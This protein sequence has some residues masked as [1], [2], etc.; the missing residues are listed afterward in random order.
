MP[1]P[2]GDVAPRGGVQLPFHRAT[3]IHRWRRTGRVA[4]L[5]GS[6][7]MPQAVRRYAQVFLGDVESLHH[8]AQVSDR[9]DQSLLRIA[10][11]FG[12]TV[13]HAARG[14]D[15]AHP[16]VGVDRHIALA[17]A[18]CAAMRE[19]V[20]RRSALRLPGLTPRCTPAWWNTWSAPAAC[21]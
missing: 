5:V 19:E 14:L 1:E 8:I 16:C 21:A 20:Q 7:L 17:L 4:V 3:S 15:G 11:A 18:F 2:L 9:L 6:V 12:L 13:G 10:H